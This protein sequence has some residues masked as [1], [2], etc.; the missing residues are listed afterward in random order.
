MT[1]SLLDDQS[2]PPDDDA[3]GKPRQLEK[4]VDALAC[5][6]VLLRQHMDSGFALL[7]ADMAAR[8]AEQDLVMVERFAEAD[9][10]NLERFAE[11][12]RRHDDSTKALASQ[13]QCQ[14]ADMDKRQEA[15]LVEMGRRLDAFSR[16]MVGLT[17]AVVVLV[18][19]MASRLY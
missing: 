18:A 17:M 4:K 7:R 8:F 3:G 1:Q 5:E 11:A 6:L 10:K 15:R 19:H 14:M 12:D 9:R 2:S 16:W 13:L